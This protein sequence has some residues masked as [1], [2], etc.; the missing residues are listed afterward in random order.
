MHRKHSYEFHQLLQYSGVQHA[1]W[2]T[3][4]RL[5]QGL[6]KMRPGYSGI[7]SWLRLLHPGNDT[8]FKAEFDGMYFPPDVRK[9]KERDFQTLGHGLMNVVQYE[10]RFGELEKFAPDLVT[11]EHRR[12]ERFYEGL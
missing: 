4:Y 1:R 2:S 9:R 8:I 11:T 10:A 6:S 12:L 3:M 5:S 7:Q